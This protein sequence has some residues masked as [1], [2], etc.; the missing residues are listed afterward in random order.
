LGY[1][2]AIVLTRNEG[3]CFGMKSEKHMLRTEDNIKMETVASSCKHGDE[4]NSF[5]EGGNFL[6]C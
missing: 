5:T 6:S 4:F 3:K 2:A 1:V